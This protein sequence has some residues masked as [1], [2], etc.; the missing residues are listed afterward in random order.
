MSKELHVHIV[1][2]IID[3]LYNCFNQVAISTKTI[4]VIVELHLNTTCTAIA[5]SS[6]ELHTY[7]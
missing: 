2:L 5:V 6:D 7:L 1:P 3:L 4:I